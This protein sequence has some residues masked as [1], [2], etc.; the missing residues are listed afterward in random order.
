[1]VWAIK[2]KTR[3]PVYVGRLDPQRH[4]GLRCECE[5][6]ACGSPLQA[7]NLREPAASTRQPFF[8]HHVG[9]QGPGC[10]Y[11]VA[12]LA[13]L[14]LLAEKGIIEIPAPRRHA[15]RIGISGTI[16]PAEAVGAAV[17]ER[18]VE[19]RLVSEVAAVLTLESG[20]K[21]AL[22]LRGHQDV[23]ELGSVF[24]VVE[25]H[26]DDPELAMLSPEEI[27]KRSELESGW[28][29]VIEHV[30]DEE[31]QLQADELARQRALD[32][33][34]IDPEALDLPVGATKKQASESLIHWAVKEALMHI[35]FLQVPEL[36]LAASAI[37]KGGIAH[38][39]P[40]SMN[41]MPLSMSIWKT[42]ER[43]DPLSTQTKAKVTP[44]RSFA[45]DVSS[46]FGYSVKP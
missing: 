39:V 14:K 3:E 23:G 31:L 4:V 45:A 42:S 46:I 30:Q 33:L 36:R 28:L 16:Y 12:E 13:A 43:A 5:C 27:L 44:S 8:R 7:V 35:G 34:D 38:T 1:M 15:N 19:R 21:V 6:P 41:G 25:V 11:R 2:G 17:R 10:K 40:T 20:R 29:H 9:T 32:K 37:G 26:V 18:I 24:A 22:V